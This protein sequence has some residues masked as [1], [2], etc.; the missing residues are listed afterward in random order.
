MKNEKYV[1]LYREEQLKVL[2]NKSWVKNIDFNKDAHEMKSLTGGEKG[3]V[4]KFSDSFYGNFNVGRRPSMDTAWGRRVF[5]QYEIDIEVK[6]YRHSY[7]GNTTPPRDYHEFGL[8]DAI[9]NSGCK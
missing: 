9:Y 8:W 2:E 1:Y 4:W 3:K 5:D 7:L 6:K